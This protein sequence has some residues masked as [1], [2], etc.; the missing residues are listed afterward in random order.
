TTE[1]EIE[2]L[3]EAYRTIR[4]REVMLY[5]IDRKT[6]AENLSKVPREELE[7]IATRF[8]SDNIKVQVN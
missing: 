3:A 5:S 4:P 1:A 2:A 8:R 7:T 6:P